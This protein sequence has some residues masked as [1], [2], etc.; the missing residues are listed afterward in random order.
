MKSVYLHLTERSAPISKANL[1]NDPKFANF[2]SSALKLDALEKMLLDGVDVN[3]TGNSNKTALHRSTQYEGEAMDRYT[4]FFLENGANPNALDNYNRTPLH[5]ASMHNN[6][7]AVKV[8]L[9]AG[10]DI[11]I[12]DGSDNT[13][14]AYGRSRVITDMF[15]DYAKENNIPMNKI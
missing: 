3:S 2:I 7:N 14:R 6:P 10:A 9:K 12:K 1:T 13:P 5:Y 15:I 4:D 8:L 11:T